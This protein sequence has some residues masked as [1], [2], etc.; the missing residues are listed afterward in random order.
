MT[1]SVFRPLCYRQILLAAAVIAPLLFST[2]LHAD[3]L[4]DLLK[5]LKGASVLLVNPDNKSIISVEPD[6]PLVPASTMKLV[7]SLLA[8]EHWGA[9]HRFETRFRL[10]AQSRLWVVGRGD[11]FWSL[12][13]S[14]L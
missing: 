14:R 11:P 7:L 9:D 1:R 10:D 3:R 5:P 8:L 12:K 4:Q 6:R 2:T 13:K